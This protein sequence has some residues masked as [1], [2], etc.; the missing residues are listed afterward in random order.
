MAEGISK[1]QAFK[2]FEN[3][4]LKSQ[5]SGLTTGLSKFQNAG[6]GN[7]FARLVLAFK[8]TANQY[9]R[10]QADAIISYSNGD[11]D[12]KQ[13]I[14]TLSIYGVI[15]PALY[16]SMSAT[17][18]VNLAKGL[19]DDDLEKVMGD[20][21]SEIL[22]QIGVSPTNAVPLLNDLTKYAINNAQGR[23]K[24]KMRVLSLP[25]IT[26]VQ[27]AWIGITKENADAEDYFK[28][29]S[30]GVEATTSLP[31]GTASRWL[32]ELKGDSG[33]RSRPRR[34]R[35]RRSRPSR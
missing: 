33:S 20:I 4:T 2:E 10:K 21:G 7:P 9:F 17:I 19:M 29:L 11:I 30:F 18:L 22:L 13:L 34:S 31:I 23:Q 25:M 28:A 27:D 8:N 3:L 14:K 32:D 35:P 6:A 5:Q 15:Q 1:E 26:D 16:A 24:N 12:K